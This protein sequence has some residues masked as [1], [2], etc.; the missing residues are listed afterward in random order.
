MKAP[1]IPIAKTVV[2]RE[3]NRLAFTRARLRPDLAGGE[4]FPYGISI[5]TMQPP[6]QPAVVFVRAVVGSG[7]KAGGH[8]H[9]GSEIL[10]TPLARGCFV[11]TSCR[12][13]RRTTTQR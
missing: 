11:I 4:R 6:Q 10:T 12:V 8:F 9:T 1:E 13:A 7:R 2:A 3:K 5:A